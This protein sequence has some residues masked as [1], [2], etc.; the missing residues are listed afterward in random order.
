MDDYETVFR[1]EHDAI[2]RTAYLVTGDRETAREVAQD[3]FAELHRHWRKVRGYDKPGAWLRRVA[4][5]RA[6]RVRRARRRWAETDLPADLASA[7]PSPSPAGAAGTAGTAG[8]PGADV[9]GGDPELLAA[10]RRLSP[11]QRAAVVLHYYEDRPVAEVAELLGCK[12]ATAGVHLH[13]ARA[14]LAELLGG[15]EGWEK[16]VDVDVPG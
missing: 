14:R 15:R 7:D 4:I 16:E 1:A 11:A 13:R 9:A 3:A 12:P 2:V 8:A 6:V 5:R 10:L